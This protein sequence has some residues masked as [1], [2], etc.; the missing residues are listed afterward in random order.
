MKKV[1]I[2]LF[3]GFCS[4]SGFGQSAIDYFEQGKDKASMGK[5]YA[6]IKDFDKAIELDKN[7]TKAYIT[8]AAA[9]EA[10]SDFSGA[11]ED[12][13]IAIELIPNYALAYFNRGL[14]RLIVFQ[15]QEGC[16]DLQKAKD[17]GYGRAEK[18]IVEKCK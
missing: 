16:N 9:K 8:R 13:S 12:Y 18:E 17:L 15:I 14:V 11:I 5:Y 4:F 3:F 7:L 2:L 10:T 1:I 6:A